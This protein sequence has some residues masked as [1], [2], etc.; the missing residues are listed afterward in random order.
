[1]I[2]VNPAKKENGCLQVLRGSHHIGLINHVRVDGQA[3]AESERMEAAMERLPLDYLELEPGSAVFFHCN[4][5]HRSDQNTSDHPRWTLICCCNA[6]RN[7][8][9][10]DS[11]HPQY[12]PL[13]KLDDEL[14]RRFGQRQLEAMQKPGPDYL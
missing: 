6:A 1:M 2:A 11:H 3:T 10:R 4:L 14:V 12:Q 7:Q 13:E 8:P 9:F 5:L